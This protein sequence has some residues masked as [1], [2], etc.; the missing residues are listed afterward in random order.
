[1]PPKQARV[2]VV[3]SSNMDLTF[4]TARLP[5]AGETLAGR[6]FHLG[7]GGKG[8]NQ[9]VMA[10]RLGAQVAM[11]SKIGADFFGERI[12]ANFREQ[13]VDV[14]HISPDD[15]QFTG[16]A[17][18]VV[19]DQANNC[20]LVIP[21]AN[22]ALTPADVRAAANAIETATVLLCQLEIP[23]ETTVEAFRRARACGVRTVLNP[24]PAADLPAELLR[25]TD[26]CIPN[27]TETEQLTGLRATS[28]SQ[29]GAAARSLLARGAGSVIVTLGQRG[30]LLVDRE[31]VEHFPA[32]A[33]QAV[34]PS[35]AGDAFI[36][37]MAVFLAE[38]LALRGALTRA[39]AV[40]ALSVTRD[41]TQAAFPNREEATAAWR[42]RINSV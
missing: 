11:V 39:N 15:R 17:G 41:G 30:A 22:L 4:R 19:D 36:G 21:G 13:G 16:V 8:A 3:G 31:S 27:E 18:I 35:G 34:D 23:V 1:M 28:V 9:A 38:G 5:R 26:L 32:P 20:I 42:D 25:L 29:A 12:L 40:A 7:F 24:A 37:S 14:T 6:A 10:A 33:V 2:C